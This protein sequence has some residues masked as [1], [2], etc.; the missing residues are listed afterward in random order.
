MELTGNPRPARRLSVT[1]ASL[2]A[3]LGIALSCAVSSPARADGA[4]VVPEGNRN[5]EQPAIPF[6]SARRTAALKS[7]YDAKF[8]RVLTVLRRDRS[9]IAD[10]KRVSA[11]YG[12]DPLHMIG[13]I[14]GEH[15]YNFDSLD[16]AQSY[17][18]KALA[19]A[20][21]SLRFQYD[22]E[23]VADFVLRPQFAECNTAARQEDSNALWTCYEGV[24]ESTF[25]GRTVD[26]KRFPRTNLNE[27]FFQ[28]LFAGQS[29]GL[30]QLNPL[31]VLK[32]TDRVARE[33]RFARLTARDANEIYQATM[34]PNISLHYMAAIIQDAIEAYRTVAGVDIS[35]NPG[36]TATLYNLGNPWGRAAQFRRSG[37]TWPQENYYGWLVNDRIEDLRSLL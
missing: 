37:S 36:L 18:V 8:E 26:G 32:M 34:D 2:F 12:I 9:L 24:W 27:T 14:V 11:R 20:G 3:A 13:A 6:A 10:I 29:F 28:P 33:S 31:T 22:G 19:Y 17:Y 1:L 21:V 4:R 7:S 16:S 30:G 15:T 23:D 5:A 25:R 35:G